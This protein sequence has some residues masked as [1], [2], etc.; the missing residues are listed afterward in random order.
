MYNFRLCLHAF[1]INCLIANIWLTHT[2][3][4]TAEHGLC[5]SPTNLSISTISIIFFYI[6]FPK[7]KTDSYLFIFYTHSYTFYPCIK[8]LSLC[9]FN[10]LVHGLTPYISLHISN[11][12]D[13]PNSP[14]QPTFHFSVYAVFYFFVLYRNSDAPKPKPIVLAFA[15][16]SSF[17][18]NNA[19]KYSFHL[20][21]IFCSFMF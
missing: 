11:A 4:T 20:F 16:L 6:P 14:H 7:H 19:E 13:N 8:V 10:H 1:F 5:S 15:S 17:P 9:F 2:P 18:F 3:S 12:H 21:S